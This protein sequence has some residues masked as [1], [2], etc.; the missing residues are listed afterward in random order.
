MGEKLNLNKHEQRILGDAGQRIAVN[1]MS[2][3][4]ALLQMH[5]S[6]LAFA[7]HA[8]HNEGADPDGGSV[9]VPAP[10]VQYHEYML[11]VAA[12]PDDSITITFTKPSGLVTPDGAPVGGN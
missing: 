12:N 10:P 6:M 4:I 7:L 8:A 1:Q 2:A 3:R 9:T 5:V 11:D